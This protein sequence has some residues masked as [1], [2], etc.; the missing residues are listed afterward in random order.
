MFSLEPETS[1]LK[2]VV[3][4]GWC[5]PNL[6]RGK[7][8]G[9]H[10]FHPL[11]TGWKSPNIHPL[12]TGWLWSSRSAKKNEFIPPTIIPS[13]SRHFRCLWP[14]SFGAHRMSKWIRWWNRKGFTNEAIGNADK[15]GFQDTYEPTNIPKKTL[16]ETNISPPKIDNWKRRFRTWKPL[17]LGANC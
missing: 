7:L 2:S 14:C 1:A 17:F 15:P 6:Y 12:E 8:V 11:K 3:S 10:H 13:F 9:T 16:P 4:M 5:F